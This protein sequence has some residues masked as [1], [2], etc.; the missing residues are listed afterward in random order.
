MDAKQLKI[1]TS[2]M[3]VSIYVIQLSLHFWCGGAGTIPHSQVDLN[4]HRTTANVR[5]YEE[6]KWWDSKKLNG[7]VTWI[8]QVQLL[9]PCHLPLFIFLT[10]HFYQAFE[11]EKVDCKHGMKTDSNHISVISSHTKNSLSK[12]RRQL[13]RCFYSWNSQPK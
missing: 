9:V 10:I 12:F 6:W 1:L 2:L 13:L 7:R 5:S 8:V 4:T 11:R 3:R